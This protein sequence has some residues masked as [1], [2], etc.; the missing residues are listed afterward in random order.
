MKNVD[1]KKIGKWIHAFFIVPVILGSVFR[2]V[3]G[4]GVRALILFVVASLACSAF[5]PRL[6]WTIP[7]PIITGLI[8]RYGA[9]YF[10]VGMFYV[11]IWDWRD[12]TIDNG[13][14][15][16]R[17]V[18]S[19]L[20]DLKNAGL[21]G[22][23]IVFGKVNGTLIQKPATMDGHVLVVGGSG[24]GKSKS[25]AI[26]SLLHWPGTGLCVDIKGE[27]SAATAH[28]R[29]KAIIFSTEERKA[30]YNPLKFISEIEDVQ[31]MARLL[32]PVPDK[33]EPFWAQSAQ[34][35]FSAA[36]WEYK[37]NKTFGELCQY[38]C[39]E[40]GSDILKA[41]RG[42]AQTETKILSNTLT[43][44]KT[45]TIASVFAEVRNKL[46]TFAVDK[47]IQYATSASDFTPADLETTTIYL[48]IS[49]SRLK[50]YGELFG[51]I[52]GQCL[53]YLTKR[54]E[55]QT[56]AV[57]LMLDEFPRLG[58]MSG[59]VEG[60]ATLRSRNVHIM[61]I[62]Q[63]LAQLDDIY[64]KDKR[65]VIVDNCAFKYVLLAADPETQKYFSDMAGQKT[66]KIKS[67]S[68]EEGW[69]KKQS[70]STQ[71]QTVPLIRPEEFAV[72]K[73]PVLF[74]FRLRP[75]AVEQVFWMNDVEMKRQ[76]E[77]GQMDAQ[78]TVL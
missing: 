10:V 67:V 49:E 9:A 41:L 71:E 21:Q 72:L 57:L 33:G 75:V 61:P 58:K 51:V 42:S 28:T 37:D 52:V 48:Q 29:D 2:S 64:G 30:R 24:T 74:P 55:G 7:I 35:V 77:S 14:E 15:L 38:L 20:R 22:D 65:K 59:F 11:L 23:G 50:Q 43:D 63:S 40:S 62:I 32:F 76:V 46:T 45:E 3:W 27:L 17:A 54:Q 5:V 25:V 39:A 78:Q 12:K 34:A 36:A 47:N 8:I 69:H 18:F 1:R 68:Q 66:A 13:G 56:P 53:R 6:F 31:E 73:N 16:G 26:P 19:S 70:F 60:L 4:R 44:L